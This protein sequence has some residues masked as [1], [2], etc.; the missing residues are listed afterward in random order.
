[1]DACPH[2]DRDDPRCASRL[3]LGRLEQAF[4]VCF[5][6][7][8]SCLTYHRINRELAA[9]MDSSPLVMLTTNGTALPLRRTG[10]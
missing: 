6:A 4:S 8:R 9:P 1:M 5:G 2:I 7:Y 3:C 10:T